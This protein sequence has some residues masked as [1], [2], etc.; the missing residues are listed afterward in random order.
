MFQVVRQFYYALH[1]SKELS[2]TTNIHNEGSQ[3]HGRDQNPAPSG[4]CLFC[5]NNGNVFSLPLPSQ[6]VP[7][8]HR[9]NFRMMTS[10]TQH[11]VTCLAEYRNDRTVVHKDL[12][13]GVSGVTFTMPTN[14]ESLW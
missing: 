1:L 3:R 10:T 12:E 7:A 8:T 11:F 4:Y 6:V 5:H 13:E 14:L 2:K 9:N